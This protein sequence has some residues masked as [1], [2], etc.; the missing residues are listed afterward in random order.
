M[1]NVNVD[2]HAN[3]ADNKHVAFV[4]EHA[5]AFD[6][7]TEMLF[8][9]LQVPSPPPPPPP[10]PL[11]V[12]GPHA[13]LFVC[14]GQHLRPSSETW[15]VCPAHLPALLARCGG[16]AWLGAHLTCEMLPR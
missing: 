5:E 1:Q 6:P 3:V 12:W 2:V 10:T 4:H 13:L 11:C 8:R 9:Y 16:Q 14:P 15:S 7:K